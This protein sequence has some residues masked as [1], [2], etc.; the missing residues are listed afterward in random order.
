MLWIIY[1]IVAAFLWAIIEIVDRHI[2]KDEIRDPWVCTSFFG[3]TCY[4]LFAILAVFTGDIFSVSLRIIFLLMLGGIIAAC[5]TIFY[6]IA[7]QREKISKLAPLFPTNVIWIV[8]LS[9]FI[10]KE[11]LLYIQYVGILILLLGVVLIAFKKGTKYKINF[12]AA[13]ILLSTLIWSFR[14]LFI[15]LSSNLGNYHIFDILFWVFL[16]YF[17]V[18]TIIFI[19]HHP[20]IIEKSKKGIEYIILNS[21]LCFIAYL[22]YVFAI[23]KYLLS[24]V[25]SVAAIT[26]LLV[27]LIVFLLT[28][29]NSKLIYEKYDKYDLITNFIATILVVIGVILI[30]I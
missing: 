16:G 11:R 13:L 21:L 23:S 17:I 7:L 27:F 19:I 28:K 8:I 25:S 30:Y 12:A 4:I 26:P 5:A 3:F 14:D 29:L 2:I 6:Y 1:P 22:V 10:L 15:K 9:Y 24:L 20:K 18:S